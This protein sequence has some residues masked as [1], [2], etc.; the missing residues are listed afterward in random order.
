MVELVYPVTA[1]LAF[2]GA[3]PVE[4][5]F[6]SVDQWSDDI[7][8]RINSAMGSLQTEIVP[9]DENAQHEKMFDRFNIN[10]AFLKTGKMYGSV[11]SQMRMPVPAQTMLQ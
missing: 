6:E 11:S 8:R 7:E 9:C 3:A 2:D 1:V 10:F 4:L 5:N